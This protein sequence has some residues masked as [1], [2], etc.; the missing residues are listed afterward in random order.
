MAMQTPRDFAS[1]L[2]D[3]FDAP[4][5]PEEQVARPN[6]SFDYLSVA[7][8]LHSGRIR[9]SSEEAAAEYRDVGMG[10]EAELA[11]LLAQVSI[12][13]QPVASELEPGEPLDPLLPI[14]PEAIA[15]ELGLDVPAAL[16]DLGR[17][18]REFAFH[19]HPDRVPPHMRQRASVRMQVANMLIDDAKRR[20]LAARR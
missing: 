11:D 4:P 7:D 1:L 13:E 20:A 2:D 6:I 18:R 17:L 9:V 15:A 12:D 16:H 5:A 3:L 14:D 8:E 19:N 10:F